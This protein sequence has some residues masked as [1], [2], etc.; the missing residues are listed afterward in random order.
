W[1]PDGRSIVYTS[2]AGGTRKLLRKPAS[3]AGAEETLVAQDAIDATE[4][5]RDGRFIS[6][7]SEHG[8]KGGEDI[9]VFSVNDRRSIA[10]RHTKFNEY[11][12]R[13][14][15]DQKWMVYVSDESGTPEIYVQTF[16]ASDFRVH[17]SMAGGVQPIWRTDG[18]ELFYLGLD[19]RL[20][21]VDVTTT[22]SFN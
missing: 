18:K 16:P 4:W 19:G 5:S 17:I 6:Y 1:S 8:G 10:A 9:D 20:M 22:P 12:N 7:F 13:L 2:L 21:A 3:G 11:E 14:S 15:P